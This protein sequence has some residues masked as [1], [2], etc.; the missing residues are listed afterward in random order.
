MLGVKVCQI[1]NT[2]I[3]LNSAPTQGAELDE[4]EHLRFQRTSQMSRKSNT[5]VYKLKNYVNPTLR[6]ESAPVA[7]CN[8]MP[9]L[10]LSNGSGGK[11]GGENPG[12]F[13]SGLLSGLWTLPWSRHQLS[14]GAASLSCLMCMYLKITLKHGMP[15]SCNR[16]LS[17]CFTRGIFTA[18]G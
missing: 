5:R 16:Y 8:N 11:W 15:R 7:Q 12:S 1:L 6:V 2:A 14:L 18:W 4:K 10:F 3:W 13:H 9:L 17:Q